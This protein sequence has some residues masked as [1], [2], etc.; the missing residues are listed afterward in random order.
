M[1]E[2]K[3]ATQATRAANAQVFQS[4]PFS[5]DTDFENARRGLISE[6]T[7]Q[8]TAT[9]GR[10]VWDLD[11]WKFLDGQAPDTANPSLWRQGKLGSIAGVFEVVDGV[12]QVRGYDLSVTSFLRTD[13][14]W[15]V[16]DPLLTQ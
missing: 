9:D 2:H 10:V 12:Y 8:I 13:T 4:L 3:P 7:G 14:G 6:S 5:D 16:V 11:L 15:V 1:S